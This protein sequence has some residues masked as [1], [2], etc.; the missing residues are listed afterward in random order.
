MERVFLG[1]IVLDKDGRATRYEFGHGVSEMVV[2]TKKKALNQARLLAERHDEL[3]SGDI[4]RW[5]FGD[6]PF[7]QVRRMGYRIVRAHVL[8]N[9]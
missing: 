9:R 3:T 1:W 5:E 2:F 8:V 7:D 6:M 4:N